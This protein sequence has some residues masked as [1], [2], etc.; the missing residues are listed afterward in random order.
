MLHNTQARPKTPHI[1]WAHKALVS[2]KRGGD[3][4]YFY[5]PHF[6]SYGQ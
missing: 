6:E 2:Q 3:L 1:A 5:H 4:V